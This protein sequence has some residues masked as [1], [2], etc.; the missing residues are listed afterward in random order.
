MRIA[1]SPTGTF[2][3]DAVDAGEVGAGHQVTALYEIK[4]QGECAEPRRGRHPAL[5]L[6]LEAAPDG[7][8]KTP[9]S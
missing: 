3:N 6:S 2:R 7:W 9:W 1:T 5:A 4:L 8:S